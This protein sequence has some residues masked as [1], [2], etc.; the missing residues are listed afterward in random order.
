MSERSKTVNGLDTLFSVFIR[1]R[2]KYTCQRCGKTRDTNV[3][4]CAHIFTRGALSTRWDPQNANALCAGCHMWAHQKPDDYLEWVENRLTTPVYK[5]LRLISKLP[6]HLGTKDL[7]LLLS[8]AR[9][10]VRETKTTTLFDK[11]KKEGE[12]P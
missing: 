1:E 5:R 12:L 3:I 7:S 6:W 4:Q 11:L 9:K 2:D 10:E 8:Q